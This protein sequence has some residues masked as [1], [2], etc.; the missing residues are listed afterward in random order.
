VII[1]LVDNRV[2]CKYLDCQPFTIDFRCTLNHV[3]VMDEPSAQTQV[4]FSTNYSRVIKDIEDLEQFYDTRVLAICS[5][6][7]SKKPTVSFGLVSMMPEQVKKPDTWIYSHPDSKS[8]DWSYCYY[9]RL[10]TPDP[11]TIQQ[12]KARS[13]EMW[14][15][16]R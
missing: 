4:Q 15:E 2:E 7:K 13:R 12:T 6:T 8:S 11:E 10:D 16:P 9:D 3:P 5:T 14:V 1:D